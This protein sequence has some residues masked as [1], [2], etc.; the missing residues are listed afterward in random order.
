V[1]DRFGR[2]AAI[3]AGAGLLILSCLAAPLSPRLAP[4][5]LTLFLLGFG[6]SLCYVGGSALLADELAPEERARTQGLTDTL[7]GLASALGSLGSG[8]VFSAVGYAAMGLVG[9]A[10][11]LVPLAAALLSVSATRRGR[12]A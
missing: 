8:V 2:P 12:R 3:A 4:L 11:A 10:A 9:A 1:A 7:V 5:A 6:W